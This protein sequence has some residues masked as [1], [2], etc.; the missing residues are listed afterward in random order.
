[1]LAQRVEVFAVDALQ[2]V[3]PVHVAHADRVRAARS[4]WPAAQATTKRSA[5]ERLRRRSGSSKPSGWAMTARS[6]SSASAVSA[7]GPGVALGQRQL[8]AGV[9]GAEAV[10]EA[11][12][13]Q[14]PDGAH[15]AEPQLRARRAAGSARPCS[16]AACGARQH[17]LEMRLASGGRVGQVGVA[18]LARE[19][20]PAELVLELLD[21]AGQRR[22]GDVALLGGAREVQRLADA[23]GS[24][25][26]RAFP[27]LMPPCVGAGIDRR[28]S[29]GQF[30][31]MPARIVH[32]G[33]IRVRAAT[34]R[35]DGGGRPRRRPMTTITDR[36][37]G[38]PATTHASAAGPRRDRHRLDQRHRPRHRRARWRQPARRRAERLRRAGAIA[39]TLRSALG[40][41]ARRAGALRRRRHEQAG[42]DRGDGRA[43]PPRLGPG[44]HPGQQRRHPARRADRGLPGGEVGRGHRDQPLGGLP[45]HARGIAGDEARGAGAG[46]S[47]SPRRTG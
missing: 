18:A 34:G 12:E 38:L 14:R 25:G 40:R 11:D 13:A 35:S 3:L 20:Q 9:V 30:T 41:T 32:A 28:E 7:S 42:R 45:R 26:S 37:P 19:Q 43:D 31:A 6:R 24:S 46:S 29:R 44:R 2:V 22:L 8:D 27:W 1:M 4:G 17:L 16:L 10:E 36:R 5:I 39:E 15:H 23:P 33:G 21:G 47:T